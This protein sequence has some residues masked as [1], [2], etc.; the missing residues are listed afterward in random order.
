MRM[1]WDKSKENEEK[2]IYAREEWCK[3]MVEGK[4]RLRTKENIMKQN[5]EEKI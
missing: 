5:E 3:I 2:K 1:R 4:E